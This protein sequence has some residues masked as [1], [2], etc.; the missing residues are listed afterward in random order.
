MKPYKS[1]VCGMQFTMVESLLF[2]QTTHKKRLFIPL[3][4]IN[5]NK[6]SWQYMR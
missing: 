5:F 2:H 4:Q 1:D 3:V 6:G